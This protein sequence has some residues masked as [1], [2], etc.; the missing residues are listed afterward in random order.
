MP[1]GSCN[2]RQ[3]FLRAAETSLM[4]RDIRIRDI[5]IGIEHALACVGASSGQRHPVSAIGGSAGGMTLF[6]VPPSGDR[7]YST[8]ERRIDALS[9]AFAG[10][11]GIAESLAR[12][13]PGSRND[14]RAPANSG[15]ATRCALLKGARRGD[16]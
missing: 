14:G 1:R 16:P 10:V 9:K 8:S 2:A 15:L 4:Q 5:R 7:M 3:P 11:V 6:R 13:L 12:R